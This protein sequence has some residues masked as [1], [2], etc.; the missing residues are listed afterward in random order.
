MSDDCTYKN[1]FFL[2]ILAI[3]LCAGCAVLKTQIDA[4]ADEKEV[5]V[6]EEVTEEV[7]G[8]EPKHE[9][10]I[11][12]YEHNVRW[13]GETV[14]IIAGWYTGDILNWKEIAA[15]NP[16]INPSLIRKGNVIYIPKQMMTTE[17]PMP[18]SY[19]DGFYPVKEEAFPTVENAP[20]VEDSQTREETPSD[21]EATPVD[22]EGEKLELIGP[23]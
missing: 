16:E 5:A 21:E 14:S 11:V 9:P 2:T 22:E 8:H 20:A 17:T 19:V 13:P 15:A 7:I 10:E 6:T 1:L 4:S 18:K 23:K 3:Y 12:F